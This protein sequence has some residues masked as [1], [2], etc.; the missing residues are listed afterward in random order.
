MTD[1][2][3]YW[4]SVTVEALSSDANIGRVLAA[5]AF[6]RYLGSMPRGSIAWW[7]PSY[8]TVPPDLFRSYGERGDEY[9]ASRRA[10]AAALN[11]AM[12]DS[13]VHLL[14]LSGRIICLDEWCGDG[15]WRSADGHN[16]GD[17]LIELGM[18]RWATTYGKAASRIARAI[19][20]QIPELAVAPRMRG[21][22]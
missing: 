13:P 10:D 8:V 12:R 9:L 16:R 20:F 2:R 5:M 4:P 1:K 7:R 21:A 22:A 14:A 17:T 11:R 19:G 15:A 3:P 6:D 18:W